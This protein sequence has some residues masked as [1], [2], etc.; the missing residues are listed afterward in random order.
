MKVQCAWCKKWGK[1]KAPLKDQS[2]SHTICPAC[3]DEQT[4]K[5]NPVIEWGFVEEFGKSVVWR[6][7]GKVRQYILNRAGKWELIEVAGYG[8]DPKV[9]GEFET[10]IEALARAGI[11]AAKHLVGGNPGE[12][13]HAGKMEEAERSEKAVKKP[14]LKDFY[15]GKAIAHFESALQARSNTRTRKNPLAVFTVGNPPNEIRANV[16]GVVYNRVCEVRAEKTGTFRKGLWRHPF[17]HATQ[18]QMLAL[19]NGDLLL[20]SV[21]GVRLWKLA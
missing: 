11:R 7:V 10:K 18:V 6:L 20:R 21:K 8:R 19:D 9:I 13:W 14:S 5:M 3:K 16:S 17:T 1:D 15:H 4:A 12:A 2:V